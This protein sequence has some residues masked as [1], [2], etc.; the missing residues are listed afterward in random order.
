MN[1]VNPESLHNSLVA[2]EG[3]S[4]SSHNN[5]GTIDILDLLPV[6]RPS[7]DSE[8]SNDPLSEPRSYGKRRNCYG[9]KATVSM[10]SR[11]S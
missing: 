9:G 10:K 11:M 4:Y 8:F 6:S 3:M 5:S 2:N 7:V 1:V